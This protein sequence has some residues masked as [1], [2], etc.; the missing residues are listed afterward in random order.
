VSRES[1]I[2]FLDLEALRMVDAAYADRTEWIKKSIRT[3]AKV[4]YLLQPLNPLTRLKPIAIDGE[5]QL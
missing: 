3:T 2:I 5:V 1:D 4:V